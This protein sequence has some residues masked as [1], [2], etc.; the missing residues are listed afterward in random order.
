MH[1]IFSS[2]LL[3]MNYLICNIDCS[4]MHYKH[5]SLGRQIMDDTVLA[6][7][8]LINNF[9]FKNQSMQCNIVLTCLG[10]GSLTAWVQIL[11][12]LVY[13]LCGQIIGQII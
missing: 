7:Q 13:Q 1:S 5:P 3:D 11:A 9:V 4:D 10:S 2:E 12:L 8:S 6:F